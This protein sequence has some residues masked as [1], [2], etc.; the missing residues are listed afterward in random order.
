MAEGNGVSRREFDRL[1]S[2]VDLVYDKGSPQV[3]ALEVRMEIE[4]RGVRED[5]QE[6]NRRLAAIARLGWSILIALIVGLVSL[7]TAVSQGLFG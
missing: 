5:I 7:L 4:L 2:R 1:E 3:R 6:Q